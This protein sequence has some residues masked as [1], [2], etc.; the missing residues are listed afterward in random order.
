V[1]GTPAPVNTSEGERHSTKCLPSQRLIDIMTLKHI[2]KPLL[3]CQNVQVP[4]KQSRISTFSGG[5]T[6]TYYFQ[7]G[8]MYERKGGKGRLGNGKEVGKKGRKRA[9]KERVWREVLPK[10]KFTTTPP[11]TS[12]SNHQI[13]V[14]LDMH[15]RQQIIG[16]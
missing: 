9:K 11:Y 8:L 14:I 1:R 12:D 6:R 15:M 16:F 2:S 5:R 4:L 3:G 13:L 7:G 10:Q